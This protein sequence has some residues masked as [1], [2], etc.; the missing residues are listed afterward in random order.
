[1]TT[2]GSVLARVR[3]LRGVSYEWKPGEEW[4]GKAGDGKREIG[5][6]AQ[7]VEANFPHAV[8]RDKDDYLMVDYL[9]LVAVLVE[10]VKEL[11]DRVEELE[12][13]RAG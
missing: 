8:R 4:R 12:A 13:K 10:A 3:N 2:N 9:G 1:M 5:V 7:D 6:I 11:A